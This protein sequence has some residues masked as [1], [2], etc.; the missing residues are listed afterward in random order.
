MQILEKGQVFS[1]KEKHVTQD[2]INRYA[3]AAGD[4]NLL[5]LNEEFARETRYGGIIAHGMLSLAFV[6]ELLTG[7]FAEK[8]LQSGVLDVSFILPVR[9]GD[10]ITVE[11]KI[12]KVASTEELQDIHMHVVCTNQKKEKVIMGKARV[13]VPLN[14]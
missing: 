9:P 6:Q 8:W 3:D 14:M 2:M 5:H 10:K 7:V 1:L 4:H 13:A 12:V 11:A